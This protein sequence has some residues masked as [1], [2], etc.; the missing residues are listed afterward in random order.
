M[1]GTRM[2]KSLRIVIAIIAAI[3]GWALGSYLVKAITVERQVNNLTTNPQA[4]STAEF[5]DGFMQGCMEVNLSGLGINQ[6]QYCGCMYDMVMENKG[7]NWAVQAGLDINNPKY[8]GDL[9]NYASICLSEQ[10]I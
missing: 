10:Y 2:N 7:M 6:T 8:Q 3:I 9:E 5:K 4:L 1:E